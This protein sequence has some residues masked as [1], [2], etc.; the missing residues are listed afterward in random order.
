M[1]EVVAPTLHP[2]W[3]ANGAGRNVIR[4]AHATTGEK[5]GLVVLLRRLEQLHVFSGAAGRQLDTAP[6]S[7]QLPGIRSRVSLAR[8]N[9]SNTSAQD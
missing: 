7:G 6:T 2:A 5:F 1:L 9:K 3:H 8:G 4:A